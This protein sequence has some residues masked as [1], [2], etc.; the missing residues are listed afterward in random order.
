MLK[1]FRSSGLKH[2]KEGGTE[3]R[4]V[5]LSA[6]V[7]FL[8]SFWFHDWF[9]TS[10]GPSNQKLWGSIFLTPFRSF[11][12]SLKIATLC[13]RAM[14]RAKN[15]MFSYNP[16]TPLD[17]CRILFWLRI[18]KNFENRLTYKVC[19]AILVSEGRECGKIHENPS[20]NALFWL[21]WVFLHLAMRFWCFILVHNHPESYY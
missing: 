18:W 11:W 13:G 1:P 5:G 14:L 16:K 3:C 9:G 17:W 20:E 8:C 2:D 7:R 12:G 19:T 21:S 6:F 10:R 15:V 4:Y